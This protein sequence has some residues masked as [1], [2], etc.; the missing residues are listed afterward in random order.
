MRLVGI[1]FSFN[2]FFPCLLWVNVYWLSLLTFMNFKRVLGIYINKDDLYIFFCF[3]NK[4]S[5]AF[6][7]SHGSLYV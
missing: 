5:Q 6:D 4:S 7:F 1:K 2:S 3:G